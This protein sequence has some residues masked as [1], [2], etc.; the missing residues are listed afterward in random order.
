MSE[1]ADRFA[2]E[3]LPG[4]SIHWTGQ[5]SRK[6]IFHRQDLFFVPFS[7]LWG[8]FAI[9]WEY[10]ALGMGPFGAVAQRPDLS[11]FLALW[12]IPFVLIGQYLIWGRF[13]HAALR[14]KNIFYAL[15]NRRVLILHAGRGGSLNAA[16]LETI[17]NIQKSVRPDGIGTL[18]FGVPA[19][20]RPRDLGPLLGI[21]TS[22]TPAFVD[23]PDAEQVYSQINRLRNENS[24][25]RSF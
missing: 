5:P 2:D 19:P 21:R 16:T 20:G 6:V 10:T 9:F 3:L 8:G 22:G 24:P 7:L 15:T 17:P 1:F 23:I 4:E 14:K 25:A 18:I 11:R 13:L 12:G